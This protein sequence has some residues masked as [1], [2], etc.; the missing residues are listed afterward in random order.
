M[1]DFFDKCREML[2]ILTVYEKV[3]LPRFAKSKR[4][5]LTQ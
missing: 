1:R 2:E 4:V 5:V 3:N